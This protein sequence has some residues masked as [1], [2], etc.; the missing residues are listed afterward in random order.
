MW[1]GQVVRLL[2]T[3]LLSTSLAAC[4]KLSNR[5]TAEKI[6]TGLGKQRQVVPVVVDGEVSEL[7]DRLYEKGRAC[8]SEAVRSSGM[9][10]T[11]S[12]GFISVSPSIRQSLERG[13]MKDGRTWLALRM[14]GLIHAVA[15]G[16]ALRQS[17]PGEVEAEVFP[18]DRHKAG[19]IRDAVSSGE[20]FCQWRQFDYPY[21]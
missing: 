9:A 2:L 11:G 7:A 13:E 19:K 3:G 8:T 21:D 1:R 12:G 5:P 20:L 18:S 4:S 17:A 16:V 14:D 6:V 15:V 10:P